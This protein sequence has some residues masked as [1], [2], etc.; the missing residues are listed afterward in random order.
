[1]VPS[2]VIINIAKYKIFHRP[3]EAMLFFHGEI[4]SAPENYSVIQSLEGLNSSY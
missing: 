1:M 3:D 4:P 2:V